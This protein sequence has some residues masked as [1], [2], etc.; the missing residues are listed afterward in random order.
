M[1]LSTS[2][3]SQFA[4]SCQL[5]MP[6]CWIHPKQSTCNFN[7]ILSVTHFATIDQLNGMNGVNKCGE[8]LKIYKSFISSLNPEAYIMMHRDRYWHWYIC[9]CRKSS[10]YLEKKST[11]SENVFT[12]FASIMFSNSRAISWTKITRYFWFKNNVIMY[13]IMR[14][15]NVSSHWQYLNANPS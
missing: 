8:L 15:C 13:F 4:K 14:L 10:D 12:E 3:I 1:F 6:N 2:W 11:R 5:K 9:V 7:H